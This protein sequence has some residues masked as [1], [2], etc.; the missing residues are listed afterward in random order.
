MPSKVPFKSKYPDFSFK[1]YEHEHRQY[2]AICIKEIKDFHK[3]FERLKSM[4]QKTWQ[5][6]RDSGIYHFHDVE[7][8]K[9]TEP[10]GF[11]C[12]SNIFKEI[13]PAWQFELFGECRVF[14]FFNSINV[15][16]IIWID[17]DHAV[18]PRKH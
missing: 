12:L 18:C 13:P 5:E 2:S 14:G 8:H 7:W 10:N 9:T 16:E 11:K 6:I 15:F 17:R 3:M 1:Y 4:S